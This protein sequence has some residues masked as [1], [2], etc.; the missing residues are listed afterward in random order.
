MTVWTGVL[1]TWVPAP[2]EAADLQI[3]ADALHGLTDARTSYNPTWTSSGTQPAI[4]NGS[5]TGSY[6]Q[7]GKLA[8]V[9]I[10]L[11]AGSTT[12]FGTG[13]YT[14]SLPIVPKAD[15]LLEALLQDSSGSVRFDGAAWII[16][17]LASGDN[18]RIVFSG[19]AGFANMTGTSPIALATSDRLILQ[20]DVEVA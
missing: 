6:L 17:A 12:T 3:M 9:R 11:L 1:P 10:V 16:A 2:V 7:A 14:F 4:G 15:Q 8:K 5:L 19:E 18:M 13:L 20:G